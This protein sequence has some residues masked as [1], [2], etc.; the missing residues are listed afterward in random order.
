MN[1]DEVRALITLAGPGDEPVPAGANLPGLLARGRRQRRNRALLVVSGSALTTAAVVLF[2][3]LIAGR[4]PSGESLRPANAPVSTTTTTT[5]K[6][7][8]TTEVPVTT[9]S[10]PTPS[11][12]KSTPG[13]TTHDSSSDPATPGGHVPT[14]TAR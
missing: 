2:V 9:G 14:S 13:T 1:E 11:S 7:L 6:P 10:A 5:T 3:V 4:A 8:T 12:T